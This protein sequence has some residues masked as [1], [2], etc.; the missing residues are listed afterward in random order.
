VYAYITLETVALDTPKIWQFL[1][2]MIHLNAHQ[3]SVLFQNWTSLP[4]SDSLTWVVTQ[5]KNQFTDTSTT[6]FKQKEEEHSVSLTEVISMYPTK[7]D[8]ISQFLSA[9]ISIFTPSHDTIFLEKALP[10]I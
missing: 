3:R 10:D 1:Q 2:Q 8:S 6:E 7:T 4:F 9:S 5:H